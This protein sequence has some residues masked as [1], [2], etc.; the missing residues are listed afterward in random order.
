MH[1][2]LIDLAATKR[3]TLVKAASACSYR[4][5]SSHIVSCPSN[6][7]L[8]NHYR[9]INGQNIASLRGIHVAA[10]Q[11]EKSGLTTLPSSLF[12]DPFHSTCFPS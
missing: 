3:S 7:E 6:E 11:P 5:V 9:H 10:Y 8:W 12:P 2:L 1:N 4:L